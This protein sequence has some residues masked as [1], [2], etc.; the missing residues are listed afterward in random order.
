MRR[1][2]TFVFVSIYGTRSIEHSSKRRI[3]STP[4]QTSADSS[5]PQG[6]LD[7]NFG[8]PKEGCNLA[9][10]MGGIFSLHC[11]GVCESESSV[12]EC[13]IWCLSGGGLEYSKSGANLLAGTRGWL[14]LC[15]G[16]S[17]FPSLC[18]GYDTQ[19]LKAGRVLLTACGTRRVGL[20]KCFPSALLSPSTVRS[21]DDCRE[22]QDHGGM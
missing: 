6:I 13:V 14:T 17:H 7:V 18:I 2:T 5:A 10:K 20:R 1:K 16:H 22:S 9:K 21:L 12:Q 19:Y 8:W 15:L 3:G 4:L 11:Y